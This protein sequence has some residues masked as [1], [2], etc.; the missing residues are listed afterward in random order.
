[1]KTVG[2][3][4]THVKP[5]SMKTKG[6]T[7]IL[8]NHKYEDNEVTTDCTDMITTRSHE[9]QQSSISIYL[10]IPKKGPDKLATTD[11]IPGV[12]G[13]T[14]IECHNCIKIN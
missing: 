2:L 5:L 1:M 7:C 8:N 13:T 14:H 6:F 12:S 10:I 3:F 11:H 9:F 4:K